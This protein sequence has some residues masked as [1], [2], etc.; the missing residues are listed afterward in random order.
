M[1]RRR[2]YGMPARGKAV[3]FIIV[4]L[5][6]ILFFD[7]Q[8]RPV[9]E[10]ITANEAKVKSVSTINTAVMDELGKDSVTYDDLITVERGTDGNV[11][12]ITTNVV[13]MNEL[14]AK[15]IDSVMK[16]LQMDSH[17]TIGVPIGTLVGGDILHGRGPSV[18]LKVT[19][20]GNVN[21]DFDSTFESAGINQT[22]H[23]IYLNIHTS[24]YSFLPGFDTTTD[25][26]TNILVAETVIVG[27]VPQVV[28][29]LK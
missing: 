22:K 25:V 26:D 7:W 28:A 15:I 13:K 8:L 11:L 10:S 17:D 9:I 24:V 21:A 3:L 19:L 20:S 5:L 6:F 2:S 1:R 27:A 23:Q 4:L 18:P 12:S 29:N 14:K 16:D